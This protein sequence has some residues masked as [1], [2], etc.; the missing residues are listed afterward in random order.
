[1]QSLATKGEVIFFRFCFMRC[2]I[3]TRVSTE[4]HSEDR[5]AEEI[6]YLQV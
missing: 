4:T 6:I 5:L 1:V 2:A 3:Y